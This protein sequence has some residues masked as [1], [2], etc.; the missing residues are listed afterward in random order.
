[1]TLDR[2]NI[3]PSTVMLVGEY[4]GVLGGST[5]TIPLN[6]FHV[7]V[8]KTANIPTG[9]EKEASQSMKSLKEL[10]HY[11]GHLP[12]GT[13][14]ALPDLELL[15]NNMEHY[16]LEITIPNGNGLGSSGA[17]SAAIYDLFFPEA[18]SVTP[19]QQKEDLAAIESFFHGKSSGVDALTSYL[20]TPLYVKED[21]SIV[22]VDLNPAQLPFGYR[23]FLLDSGKRFD[24]GPQIKQFLVQMED[25]GFASSVRH[26]YMVVNQ[27]LIESLLGERDVDPGLLVRVLSD[28]QF[29]H[30]RE[31]IPSNLV[32]LWI[33]G[34]ISNE[35][36]LKLNG[37][38]GGFLL[39]ITHHT[40]VQ[41]L[42]DR[43]KK[44][45]IWIS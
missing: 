4:G 22:K 25:S 28:F 1:M 24:T 3:Y 15:S 37:P 41:K 32:D 5:I 18:G 21:G 8:R 30:F 16:W 20:G 33:E 26:E 2:D 14:H 39:G 31:M 36:Y 9:L 10:Y 12:A 38:G 44:D 45:L 7:R 6:N 35:Y 13:F 43:W 29:T 34:Q 17:V 11:V 23:F 19:L 27:K 40:S 42:T